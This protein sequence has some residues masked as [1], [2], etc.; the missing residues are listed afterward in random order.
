L[1]EVAGLAEHVGESWGLADEREEFGVLADVGSPPLG[2]KQGEFVRV[3]GSLALA[4]SPVL[5]AGAVGEDFGALVG[6]LD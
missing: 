6:F 4:F 5:G 1:A 2:V 3:G